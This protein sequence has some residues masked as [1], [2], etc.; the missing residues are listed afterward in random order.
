MSVA[1]R[2]ACAVILLMIASRAAGAADQVGFTSAMRPFADQTLPQAQTVPLNFNSPIFRFAML[3]TAPRGALEVTF[4]DRSKLSMGPASQLVIDQYVYAGSGG[5]GQQVV[6]YTKGAFR[7]ISGNIPKDKVRIETPTVTVGIRGTTIRTLVT[8]D[9][10]TTVGLDHGGAIVTS[11]QTGQSV[12]LIP[13][14]KVT[15]KPNGEMGPV[16]LGKVEGCP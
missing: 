6:R 14:E 9:G 12:F 13:G 7:F 3:R 8:D 16:T 2:I 4:L 11:K 10:T 15:I 1:G 5:T